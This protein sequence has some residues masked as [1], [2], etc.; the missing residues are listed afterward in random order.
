MGKNQSKQP[1]TQEQLYKIYN[2]FKHSHKAQVLKSKKLLSMDLVNDEPIY[3][4]AC[5]PTKNVGKSL[6]LIIFICFY[7]KHKTHFQ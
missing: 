5:V 4:L 6:I 1:L 3:C 2:Q 7:C